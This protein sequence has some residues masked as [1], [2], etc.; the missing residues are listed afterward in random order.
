MNDMEMSEMASLFIK[1][2]V[3]DLYCSRWWSLPGLNR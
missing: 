2:Q 3:I 1:K